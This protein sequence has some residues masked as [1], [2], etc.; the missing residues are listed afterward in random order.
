MAIRTPPT[1]LK[2]VVAMMFVLLTTFAFYRGEPGPDIDSAFV[3]ANLIL[4]CAS[5]VGLTFFSFFFDIFA[6]VGFVSLVF[7]FC[8]LYAGIQRGR[9]VGN[10]D[11]LPE[12]DPE[13][14]TAGSWS[15]DCASCPTR[16]RIERRWRGD[17]VSISADCG[18]FCMPVA[19]P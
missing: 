3:A 4:L 12:Y 18:V 17:V 6:S 14:S 13:R 11:Y 8:R 15:P 5:F 7:G 9:A 1:G 16:N 19:M 2:Y 10:G